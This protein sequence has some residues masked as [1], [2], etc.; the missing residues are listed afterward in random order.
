MGLPNQYD[1]IVVGAG[2]YWF[3]RPE[4]VTNAPPGDGPIVAFGNSL[5]Y[6]VGAGK[7]QGYVDILAQSIQRPILNR[8]VSGETI[9]EASR[10]VDR[11]VLSEKPSIVIV[12]L[13]SA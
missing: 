11:D 1:V 6:G 12:L 7:G 13:G 10:R 8:G 9:A 3:L 5:T 4:P 2:V